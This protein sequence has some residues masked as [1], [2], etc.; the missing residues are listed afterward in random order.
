[1]YSLQRGIENEQNAI[2]TVGRQLAVYNQYRM[3]CIFGLFDV[4]GFTSFCENCDPQ[5][6]ARVLKIVD[7]FETEIPDLLLDALDASDSTPKEKREMVKARLKWL[8]FSDTFFVA[9][10]IQATDKPDTLK[11]NLIFFTL[12]VAYMNRRMFEIGLPL[13][14]AVHVGNVT[15]SKRCFAGKAVM[16]AH[17]LSTQC[18]FAGAVVSDEAHS[19]IFDVFKKPDGFHLMF[20]QLIIECCAS[21]GT[22]PLS[23]S[24]YENASQKMKT[25]CW[26]FLEMGRIG[27]FAIP[28]DLDTYVRERFT[29]H[30]K[31]LPD[32]KETIKAFNT[33]RLLEHWKMASNAESRQEVAIDANVL[34]QKK[35]AVERHEL[36]KRIKLFLKDVYYPTP[37]YSENYYG[38]IRID[39]GVV[40][41][42]LNV[43]DSLQIREVTCLCLKYG[44]TGPIQKLENIAQALPHSSN[45]FSSVSPGQARQIIAKA[46]RKMRHP[47]R[48]R[49]I[50]A[51][52]GGVE[53]NYSRQHLKHRRSNK[54]TQ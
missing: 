44:V 39:D 51:A 36:H 2:E 3:N 37:M 7:D 46:L 14:G 38:T 15:L 32:G 6:A 18:Q 16:D 19:L 24:L 53:P 40:H 48:M 30:G 33:A 29:A 31:K 23:Q 41:T 13:R 42:V 12:L 17:R 47:T 52:M 9:M 1:M 4:L 49:R 22:K 27:R 8:T 25:L 26:I 11:F 50:F 21:T 35:Q 43:L 54:H 28:S 10:P 45:P 20:S 5:E 34:V